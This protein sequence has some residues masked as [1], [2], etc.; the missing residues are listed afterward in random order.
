MLLRFD[1]SS[2]I[3]HGES[4][5]RELTCTYHRYF[6][7]L[8]NP[9]PASWCQLWSRLSA[10]GKGLFNRW[11]GRA[12]A[13]IIDIPNCF[14]FQGIQKFKSFMWCL[15]VDLFPKLTSECQ[16]TEMES[17]MF[18]TCS[19]RGSISPEKLE[20]MVFKSV[21]KTRPSFTGIRDNI[22]LVQKENLNK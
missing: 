15:Y 11:F 5:S 7:H 21:W 3:V 16:P 8:P 18:S 20:T 2:S 19:I 13:I 1:I 22:L 10:K 12:W 4:C 17:W 6:Q 14:L 9:L